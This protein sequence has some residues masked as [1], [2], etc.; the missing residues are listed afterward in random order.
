MVYPALPVRTPMIIGTKWIDVVGIF[1]G[2]FEFLASS[3]L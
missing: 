3:R 2:I 1:G